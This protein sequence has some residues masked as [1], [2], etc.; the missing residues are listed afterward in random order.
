[1]VPQVQNVD[2]RLVIL[3]VTV[4]T[5]VPA[6]SGD[7][8]TL[9]EEDE[10]EP[11]FSTSSSFSKH[12]PTERWSEE[13]TRAF[14]RALR[15]CGTDFSLMCAYFPAR[16]RRQLRNKFAKERRERP[17]LVDAAMRCRLDLDQ[18]DLEGRIDS[19]L[20]RERADQRAKRRRQ[21]DESDSEDED[22]DERN[23]AAAAA[24]AVAATAATAAAIAGNAASHS[25]GGGGGGGGLGLP[26]AVESL[27]ALHGILAA[28]NPVAAT[29]TKS[30]TAPVAASLAMSSTAA[31]S[32]GAAKGGDEAE[33]AD[34][35]EEG[36][37]EGE[38][39]E[40]E[41]EEEEE[42][43]EEEEEEEDETHAALRSFRRQREDE[44]EDG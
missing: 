23:G 37:E 16:T 26:V 18:S 5:E 32:A 13:D 33:E 19:F 24:G 6:S 35:E 10:A 14:F 29:A 22:E 1:M 25:A 3:S 41:F 40:G 17:A 4:N 8:L 11:R 39:E 38:E 34:E 31:A 44:D 27:P 9:V 36:E 30:T 12:E 15:T 20:E 21:G 2:G 42:E 7:E 28:G 43:A